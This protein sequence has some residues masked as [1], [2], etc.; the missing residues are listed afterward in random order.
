MIKAF[1]NPLFLL[2]FFS[3]WFIYFN[4]HT[5]LAWQDGTP[6][7]NDAAIYYS[8]IEAAFVHH[9]IT[10]NFPGSENYGFTKTDKGENVPRMTMGVA[11]LQTPFFFLA[12]HIARQEDYPHDGHSPPYKWIIHFGLIFYVLLGLYFLYK[13][14]TFYF[15][16]WISILICFCLLYATNLFYYCFGFNQMSHGYLFF[17]ACLIVYSII[18]WDREKKNQYL[19]LGSFFIGFATL[20]RPTEIIWVLMPLLIGVDSF[21]SFI[22]RLKY[23][24]TNIGTTLLACVSFVIPIVPQLMFWKMQSGDWVFYSYNDERFFFGDS[25]FLQ[26]LINYHNGLLPYSPILILA[27]LGL[28]PLF[29]KQ[30]NI[31]NSIFFF[32]IINIYVLSSW[33]MW[34]Y[35]GSL[36]ARQ[37]IQSFPLMAFPMA[38]LF[39]YLIGHSGKYLKIISS[40]IIVFVVMYL[41]RLNMIMEAQFKDT[42]IHWSAMTKDAYWLVLGKPRLTGEEW[43][44]LRK[45]QKD[46]DASLMKKGFRDID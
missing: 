40:S 34:T 19:V 27:F 45:F 14:L 13:A 29:F 39:S 12:D 33:W 46:P 32:L 36:G 24:K 11:L 23:F 28:V 17:L 42:I 1:R 8:Y 7:R 9:D 44:S 30:R 10:F 6:F 37:Y 22:D 4:Y 18:K 41:A 38:S 35:A 3:T 2:Y 16:K 43:D 20:V 31:F 25:K 21:R 15:N 26:S 5:Y